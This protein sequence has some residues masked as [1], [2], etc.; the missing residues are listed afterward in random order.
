MKKEYIG[1]LGGGQLGMMFTEAAHEEDLKVLAVDPK[2][3]CSISMIADKF[4]ESE[5]VNKSTLDKII[6][7]CEVCTTEFENVPC[8]A[9]EYLENQIK[10]F[11]SSRIMKIVQNRDLEKKFLKENNIP[12]TNFTKYNSKNDLQDLQKMEQDTIFP[13]FI[14]T[15]CF[16]YDGKGQISVENISEIEKAHNKLNNVQCI[17]ERKVNLKLE[18]SQVA[19]CNWDGKVEFLPI[20]ENHHI[21]NILHTSKVPTTIS[22]SQKKEIQDITKKIVKSLSYIGVICVEFFISLD[23]EIMVNEIAPRT[24]NSGHYSIEACD[25]SQFLY[26]AQIAGNKSIKAS[27]LNHKAIMLNLL[28]DL[29]INGEPNFDFLNNYSNIFLHLYNK[30]N[31]VPGRKMGHLTFISDDDEEL[32]ILFKKVS[33]EISKGYI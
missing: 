6:E 15:S 17:I 3:D 5:Y 28:G 10:V 20:S 4:I 30:K 21:N 33:D 24:H 27:N 1:M 9:L 19:A 25:I 13:A 14:K 26:Q 12:V 2:A 29:W 8:E 16:G 31:G 22:N 7:N 18:V 11:P 32:K 23:D